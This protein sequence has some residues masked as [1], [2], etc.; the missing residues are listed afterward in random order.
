M[1]KC[2]SNS[3][4]L[5]AFS[6][7]AGAAIA[8]AIVLFVCDTKRFGQKTTKMQVFD[9]ANWKKS[10][11]INGTCN[12]REQCYR[13]AVP[14]ADDDYLHRYKF[15]PYVLVFVFEWISASFALFYLRDMTDWIKIKNLNLLVTWLCVAWNALGL[16]VYFTWLV[17][18]DSEGTAEMI[19]VFTSF[20]MAF[21]VHL[22]YESWK[23]NLL[24]TLRPSFLLGKA[25][26][27]VHM[28][29]G[30]LWKVPVLGA[31]SAPLLQ[32][33]PEFHEIADRLDVVLRFEE[34]CVTASLLYL[35]VLFVFVVEPPVWMAVS[36]FVSIFACNAFG[37]PLQVM[38]IILDGYVS[39]QIPPA[40]SQYNADAYVRGYTNAVWS[41][42]GRIISGLAGL[43]GIGKWKDY[44]VS[45]LYFLGG[46]W[47]G[48]LN[49]V[50]IILYVGRGYMFSSEL[51]G[52]VIFALWNLIVTYSLFGIVGSYFYLVPNSWGKLDMA[53]DILSL[54]AKLPIAVNICVAFLQM[55]G[56][57]CK[58]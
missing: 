50:F 51:P 21:L 22:F 37:I 30:R 11:A 53:L 42:S 31:D 1:T 33:K 27:D 8:I 44:W 23:Q 4:K 52:F 58:A 49:G 35:S 28:L 15:N 55:P 41:S 5:T 12:S 18:R 54:A 9:W 43:F 57:G 39:A 46:A 45:K 36:G 20:G 19:V 6:L 2:L 3:V 34:Y 56:G 14:W 24:A 40:R 13:D 25:K 7:H 17:Q 38:Q 48:L 10:G 26:Y 29:H 16:G 32:V 47:F